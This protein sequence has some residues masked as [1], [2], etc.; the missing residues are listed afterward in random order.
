M[1]V[2][3]HLWIYSQCIGFIK[4]KRLELADFNFVYMNRW[5]HKDC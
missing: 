2:A 5:I 4:L 1:A 3:V